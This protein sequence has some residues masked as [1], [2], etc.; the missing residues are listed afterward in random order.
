MPVVIEHRSGPFGPEPVL[1]QRLPLDAHRDR[2]GRLSMPALKRRLKAMDHHPQV[3]RA[4]RART[5]A[6]LR[7]RGHWVR[8]LADG[9]L[10]V[11]RR[12]QA[13]APVGGCLR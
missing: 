8:V 4:R 5:V 9:T 6:D 3:V 2:A 13:S 12:V 11:S 1:T 7:R 10:A